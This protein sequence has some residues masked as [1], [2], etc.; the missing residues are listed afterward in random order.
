MTSM[1]NLNVSFLA[2]FANCCSPS[3]SFGSS[4][5]SMPV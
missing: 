2:M 3:S 4:R 5:S 1:A